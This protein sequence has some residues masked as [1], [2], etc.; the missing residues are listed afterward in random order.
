MGRY[1]EGWK[2]MYSNLIMRGALTFLLVTVLAVPTR[3][4]AD[5]F[6]PH[7]N[8]P[9]STRLDMEKADNSGAVNADVRFIADRQAIINHHQACYKSLLQAAPRPR[10]RWTRSMYA[11]AVPVS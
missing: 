10:I 2:S 11:P 1:V 5:K 6:V 4:Q 9:G 7:K 3:A 8:V